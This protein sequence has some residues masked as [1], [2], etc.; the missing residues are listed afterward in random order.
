MHTSTL[1]DSIAGMFVN[2]VMV[3][4]AR[5]LLACGLELTLEVERM[6]VKNRWRLIRVS[7]SRHPAPGG[8]ITRWRTR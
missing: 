8:F 3:Y 5:L 4:L 6:M 2:E 1:Y 7:D